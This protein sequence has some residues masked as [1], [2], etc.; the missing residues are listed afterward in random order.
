MSTVTPIHISP[1]QPLTEP[2]SR[3]ITS[4]GLTKS[5]K[6]GEAEFRVLKDL[7]FDLHPGEFVAIEGRSGSGKST[8]LHILAALDAVDSGSVKF[9]GIDYT[10]KTAHRIPRW[11][12][13]ITLRADG[14]VAGFAS[15]A[16][17][18][19]LC[20]A[21]LIGLVMSQGLVR[22]SV[23][24]PLL[25]DALI[26][27][28]AVA[29]LWLVRFAVFVGSFLSRIRGDGPSAHLR[30]KQFGFIFQFYHLLP[31][32]NVVENTMLAPSIEFS[33]LGFLGRKAQLRKR[34]VELLTRLGM[35]HRLKHRPAQLSG[36]ERQRVAI[37]RAL[38]NDPKVLFAD[39]PTGNLDAETGRQIMDLLEQLHRD[40]RQTIVMVTHDRSLAREADRV[41]V[42]QDGKLQSA[43]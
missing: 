18:A 32:L 9:E 43:A 2:A 42:L 28:A 6:M 36:G 22:E 29:A 35:S 13:I 41:L 38:M 23:Q 16:V 39:E 4:R 15:K 12:R 25:L 10:R 7:D 34:A 3:V 1:E 37:A 14:G 31:E 24:H 27:L 11:M 40:H 19:I 5:F 20:A 33:W 30:N 8:L 26:V 17:P 21:G